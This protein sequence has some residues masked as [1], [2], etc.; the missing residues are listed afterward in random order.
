MLRTKYS[1]S[2]T[3]TCQTPGDK[4]ITWDDGGMMD[5]GKICK[6]PCGSRGSL[7]N[8]KIIHK[9]GCWNVKTMYSSGKTAQITSEK[10]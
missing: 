9:I 8:P 1:G 5:T 2:S 3:T 4:F 7:A 6:E 10:Q